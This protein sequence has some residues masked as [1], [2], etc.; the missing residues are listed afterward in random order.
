MEKIRTYLNKIKHS[1]IKWRLVLSIILTILVLFIFLRHFDFQLLFNSIMSVNPIYVIIAIFFFVFSL[2]LYSWRWKI[3]LD[4]KK[5]VNSYTLFE[6]VLLSHFANILLPVNV[7]ELFRA[8]YLKSKTGIKLS[9][10]FGTIASERLYRLLGYIL[11][12][13]FVIFFVDIPKSLPVFSY[14]F[15]LLALIIIIIFICLVLLSILISLNKKKV[16][17]YSEKVLQIFYK[18]RK[19]KYSEFISNFISGIKFGSSIS[20]K[21]LIIILTVITKVMYA[22]IMQLVA[23]SFGI[24]LP[25]Y[26]FI[27]IDVIVS[28][29]HFVGN[30]ILGIGASYEFAMAFSMTL[31]GASKELGL[32]VA[33]ILDLVYIIPIL[34]WSL[35]YF[36]REGFAQF[37]KFFGKDTYY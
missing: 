28:F 22:F 7:G 26:S 23:L 12:L 19:I 20:D 32:G 14:G 30:G 21:I 6:A 31:Y 27:L 11:A 3:I 4:G 5:K 29:I 8:F 37:K 2:I 13:V 24:Y 9:L 33:I 17:K 10:I 35:F 16:A 1:L 15:I 34:V 25:L 36:K 18:P